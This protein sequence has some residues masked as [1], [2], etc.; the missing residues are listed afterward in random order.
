MDSL[1]LC[2]ARADETF[3]HGLADFL[4]L[5]LPLAVF[6]SEAI[7]GPG[8][9]LIEATERAL[10]AEAALVLLSPDSVPKV[11]IREQ[12]QPV[13][14]E[15]P[16]E[17]QTRLGYVKI[18]NCEFPSR[19]TK[20]HFFDASVDPLQALR[21]IKRWLLRP[22]AP[23][24]AGVPADPTLEDLRKAIADRP[25]VAA[26][27][28]PERAL[29]FADNCAG[30]FEAVYQLNLEERSRAGMTGDIRSITNVLYSG[31]TIEDEALFQSWC[32]R[33][34]TLFLLAG[35][36]QEDFE[37]VAPRGRSSVIFTEH[38]LPD[39]VPSTAADAVRKFEETPQVN[40]ET[41][42][43]LGWAAVNLLK[44]Q[45]RFAEAS[46][47][48]AIMAHDTRSQGDTSALLRIEREQYWTQLSQGSD[49]LRIAPAAPG[50]AQQLS[51]SFVA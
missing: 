1:V 45:L 35:V 26:D 15:K 14:F 16:Q 33:H 36:K 24:R 44:Q 18:S 21:N 9:D 51:F 29:R 32:E 13:F 49:D 12:W 38:L 19:F 23:I 41:R 27:I 42:L 10:S 34:R 3:A 17:F 28:T 50:A 22:L 40:S 8:L 20:N 31:R 30:D 46:E 11:W 2:Y 4:E 7:V 6:C 25:G 5:N 47:V 39:S 37:Y 43:R 48:L